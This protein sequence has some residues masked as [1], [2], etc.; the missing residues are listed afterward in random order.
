MC[1]YCEEVVNNAKSLLGNPA[2]EKQIEALVSGMCSTLGPFQGVC[3][4]LIKENLS[5]ILHMIAQA[6]TKHVCVFL[7]M[8]SE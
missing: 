2:A 5:D 6:D 3:E 8:C 7:H 1:T 4:Q